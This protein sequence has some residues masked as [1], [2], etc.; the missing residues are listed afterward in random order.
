MVSGGSRSQRN[1][2]RGVSSFPYAVKVFC[3]ELYYLDLFL[4]SSSIPEDNERSKFYIAPVHWESSKC[5]LV[6]IY[7]CLS[8]LYPEIAELLQIIYAMLCTAKLAMDLFQFF[9]SLE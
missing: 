1:Y 2:I 6:P 8:P 7:S 4:L 9:L 3:S 5:V